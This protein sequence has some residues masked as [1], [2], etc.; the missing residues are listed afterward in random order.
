MTAPYPI[1]QVCYPEQPQVLFNCIYILELYS[2]EDLQIQMAPLAKWCNAEYIEK[3]VSGIR[4]RDNTIEFEDG[5][6]LEYDVI[7][8]NVGSRT[9]GSHTVKGVWE[10]SLTT[11]PINELIGK[12]HR[13]ELEFVESKSIPQ[14]MVCGAGAAGVELAF[15]F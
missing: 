11:R 15:A 13:K 4:A 1:T 12:I 14:V 2:E 3:R 9:R 8:L 5:T 7:A 10:N 6:M